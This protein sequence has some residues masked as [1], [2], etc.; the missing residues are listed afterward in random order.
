MKKSLKI[1]TFHTEDE[2]MAFWARI[3]LAD[4]FESQD[5]QSIS[6][7]NLKPASRPISLRLPESML[8]R[9]KEQANERHIPYQSLI[10]QYIAAG[11][12]TA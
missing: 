3:D 12:K 10:K 9:L 2:E 5:L 1:P 8:L 4:Y 7:P 11:L 6:F